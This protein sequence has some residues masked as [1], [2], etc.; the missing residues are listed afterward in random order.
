MIRRR[1]RLRDH[2]NDPRFRK[3][4]NSIVNYPGVH[5]A[6]TKFRNQLEV[7]DEEIVNSVPWWMDRLKETSPSLH[8]TID[9]ES[10]GKIWFGEVLIDLVSLLHEYL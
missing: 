2:S 5:F 9:G 8:D 6:L 3:K 4:L 7:S 10:D 1:E